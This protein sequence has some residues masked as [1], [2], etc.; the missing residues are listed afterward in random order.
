MWPEHITG[1]WVPG[2]PFHTE[3]SRSLLQQKPTAP[4]CGNG[5]GPKVWKGKWGL[6]QKHQEPP[7]S[8]AKSDLE[9]EEQVGSKFTLCSHQ[10]R[11]GHHPSCSEPPPRPPL[12]RSLPLSSCAH[13]PFPRPAPRLARATPS[14][15]RAK[16]SFQT[17]LQISTSGCQSHTKSRNIY[18]GMRTKAGVLLPSRTTFHCPPRARSPGV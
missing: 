14:A 4:G 16:G 15:S 13:R 12:S 5:I 11:T 10:E 6:C 1:G 17:Y 7:R 18:C 2:S 8:S 9:S 3:M